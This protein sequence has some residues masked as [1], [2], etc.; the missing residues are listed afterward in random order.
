MQFWKSLQK[1]IFQSSH[2]A[3]AAP[4]FQSPPCLCLDSS[5]DLGQFVQEVKPLVFR[6]GGQPQTT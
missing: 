6:M 4:S 2:Y 5:H 1:Q 3:A